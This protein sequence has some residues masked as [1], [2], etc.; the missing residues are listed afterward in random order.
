[1]IGV[2]FEVSLVAS[3]NLNVNESHLCVFKRHGVT[4]HRFFFVQASL[5]RDR[6]ISWVKLKP[7]YRAPGAFERVNQKSLKTPII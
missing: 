2:A 6:L 3:F 4:G 1:M 5:V 7:R